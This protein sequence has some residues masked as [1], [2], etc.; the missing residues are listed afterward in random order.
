MSPM[1]RQ[2]VSLSPVGYI[3]RDTKCAYLVLD[4]CKLIASRKIST[5]GIPDSPLESVSSPNAD[6][7][8]NG[9]NH[10]NSC[11]CNYHDGFHYTFMSFHEWW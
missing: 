1:S 8:A 10:D 6:E 2:P 9:G 4:I 3:A 5:C 11:K 7:S